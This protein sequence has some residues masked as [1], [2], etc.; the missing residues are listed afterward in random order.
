MSLGSFQKNHVCSKF[1][2]CNAR[3]LLVFANR[4]SEW[5]RLGREM[6][7]VG[8]QGDLLEPGPESVRGW[9]I[10]KSHRQTI[11]KQSFD[12]QVRSQTEF[13]NEENRL[14][15]ISLACRAVASCVGGSLVTI[16]LP[17]TRF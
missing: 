5:K 15:L 3:R 8:N 10:S 11:A 12:R 6:L 14:S 13:G 17:L 1:L 4:K 9:A 16:G 2:S 7:T